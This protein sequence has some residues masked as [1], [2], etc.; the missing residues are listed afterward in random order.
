MKKFRFVIIGSG[1]RSL[2]YVRIA[3]ALPNHFELCAMLCRTREKAQLIG[4]QYAI[5][6]TTSEQECMGYLPDFAVIAVS[7]PQVAPTAIRW[8]EMGIP[9]FSETPAALEPELLDR[10]WKLHLEGRKIT[11][12][13]QYRLYPQYRALLEVANS[14][15]LGKRHSLNISL[16]HEY[17]GASLM[18]KLLGL[19]V[20][21]PF[22]V[23]SKSRDFEV[24]ETLTRYEQFFDGRIKMQT[25]TTACFEFEGNIIAFYDFDPQQYR[26]PIR[27]NT[28]KLCG[29]RGE[30]I[31]NTVYY[32]DKDNRPVQSEIEITEKEDKEVEKITFE[33][34][35]LYTPPFGLCGL[36]QDE[37][38]V[39]SLMYQAA[40]GNS[41]YP[42]ADALEDAYTTILMHHSEK[43]GKPVESTRQI[44]H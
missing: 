4:N 37:T 44:W 2:F 5:H 8:A 36:N 32:L 12:A 29:V 34:K 35:P 18:R 14:G 27:R 28:M 3:K 10:M 43:E 30:I 31:D 17:H 1:W 15:I 11:I 19:T 38:A 21:T 39:A 42:L 23:C 25:R 33:G 7:K 9:V 26:S 13:E 20:G 40:L 16:A 6:T 24:T 22:S 41:P